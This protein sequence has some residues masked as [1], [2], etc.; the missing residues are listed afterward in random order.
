MGGKS[1]KNSTFLVLIA[2]LKQYV[3]LIDRKCK[4]LGQGRVQ[5]K[6]KKKVGNFPL[7]KKNFENFSHFFLFIFKHGL[8]HP[9]MKRNFFSKV[10]TPPSFPSTS[11]KFPN[12]FLTFSY[13]PIFSGEGYLPPNLGMGPLFQGHQ[14]RGPQFQGY[15]PP[16][17]GMGPLFQGHLPQMLGV[18]TKKKISL[19]KNAFQTPYIK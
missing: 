17:L 8:N 4:I 19:H 12:L 3:G 7:G 6:K 14:V 10:G 15:L 13:L 9:K 18:P 16:N 5:K 2:S 1:I 11:G